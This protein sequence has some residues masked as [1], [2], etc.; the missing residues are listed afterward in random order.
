M[1]KVSTTPLGQPLGRWCIIKSILFS[2][3]VTK[4]KK[5]AH[6][7]AVGIAMLR[8]VPASIIAT[9]LSLMKSGKRLELL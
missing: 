7:V 9:I 5:S 1:R 3:Q 2:T 6:H 4:K 8:T